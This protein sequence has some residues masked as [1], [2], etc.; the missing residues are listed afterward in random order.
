MDKTLLGIKN[1]NENF[2]LPKTKTKTTIIEKLKTYTSKD[3]NNSNNL[4]FSNSNKLEFSNSN[5]NSNSTIIFTVFRYLLAFILLI[6]IVVNIL[7]ALDLLNEFL[8]KK[9]R[10]MLIFFNHSVEKTI[11]KTKSN[12]KTGAETLLNT[13]KL[14]VDLK[15]REDTD[16]SPLPN[17]SI[18]NKVGY[19]Y[20]GTDR[21]YRSCIEVNDTDNCISG[22]VFPTMDICINPNLRQ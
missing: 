8:K 7:A 16:N 17:D 9:L 1:S 19:C 22:D 11:E 6:F 15:N 14:D 3:L 21:G 5:T 2:S 18:S 10:P 4:E 20:V 12:T 13:L